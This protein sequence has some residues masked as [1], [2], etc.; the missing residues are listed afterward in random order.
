MVSVVIQ[1][2][3]AVTALASHTFIGFEQLGD[4]TTVA[5]TLAGV[6]AATVLVAQRLIFKGNSSRQCWTLDRLRHWHAMLS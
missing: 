6:I 2:Q 5:I 4:F 1:S 3:Q